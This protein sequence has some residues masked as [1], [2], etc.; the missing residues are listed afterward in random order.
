MDVTNR[1]LLSLILVILLLIIRQSSINITVQQFFARR[2]RRRRIGGHLKTLQAIS[3]TSYILLYDW[4]SRLREQ[5]TEFFSS[6]T[7]MGSSFV[8]LDV[9]MEITLREFRSGESGYAQKLPCPWAMGKGAS[10]TTTNTCGVNVMGNS[11][12]LLT[13]SSSDG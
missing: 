5:I 2:H 11:I 7:V 13:Y 8:L 9:S 12:V 1:D 4:S 10:V 6:G 3:C